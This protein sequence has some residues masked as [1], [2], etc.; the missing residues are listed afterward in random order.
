MFE[1]ILVPLDGSALAEAIL[2]HVALMAQ[3]GRTRVL[4]LRTYA[5]G[6]GAGGEYAADTLEH[7]EEAEKY[8]ERMTLRVEGEGLDV[9]GLARLGDAATTVL[10]TAK[11]EN[12]SL[13]AMTTHG[14]AGLH[15]WIFGSVAEKVLRASRVPVHLVRS[16]RTACISLPE[17]PPFR[18]ILLPVDGSALSRAAVPS[19][20]AFARRFGSQIV[21]LHV[22]DS[23]V[24]RETAGEVLQPVTAALGAEGVEGIVA[25]RWG[26]AAAEIL[27]ACRDYSIDLLAMTTHGRSGP[28]R[29][30]FGSVTEKV[31]RAS[32]VPMLV[33]R[34]AAVPRKFVGAGAFGGRA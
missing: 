9:R 15:R 10:D 26:D 12:A 33:V 17:G 11:E 30:A 4:L 25:V 28:S 32:S 13:I 6:A 24:D 3:R 18:N 34:G 8:I 23:G 19:L 2:P 21:V 22:A 5:A 16:F 31:L 14:R 1:R 29:W 20:A 7:K 27:D